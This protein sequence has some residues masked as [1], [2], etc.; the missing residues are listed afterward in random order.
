MAT[1]TPDDRRRVRLP[2][3][4]PDSRRVE[5]YSRV[6][7]PYFRSPG[8]FVRVGGL[9]LLVGIAIGVLVLRAWSIQILHGPQ[10]K[11]QAT[12]QAFRTVDLNGPRGAIVDD[13][14][15]L[16]ANTTG[17]V[18]V[19]ADPG[20]LGSFDAHGWHTSASGLSSLQRLSQLAHVPVEK[21]QTRIARAVARSPAWG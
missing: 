14:G 7:A 8:F 13:K 10:Y 21:L 15:R 17:H 5:P 4:L 11:T 9:A 2:R 16:L 3:S 1:S 18:V 6:D 12:H 20:T 19:V